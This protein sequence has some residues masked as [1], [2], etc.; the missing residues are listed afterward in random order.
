MR[1]EGHAFQVGAARIQVFNAGDLGARLEQWISTVPDEEKT[2]EERAAFQVPLQVPMQCV[3]IAL[4]G[5]SVLVDAASYDAIPGGEYAIPGYRPPDPLVA[6]LAASGVP[7]ESIDAVLIT[8]LHFDHYNG[9][10]VDRAGTLVPTYPRARHY[11]GRADLEAEETQQALNDPNTL[12]GR[13]L[14]V[15]RD[16]GLLAPVEGR[17]TVVPGISVISAP[18][19]SPGHQVVRVESEGQVLYCLGDL[20]HH[21]LEVLH[22]DWVV[23]WADRDRIA[24]SRRALVDAALQERALLIATHIRGAGR[25]VA[26]GAGIEWVHEAA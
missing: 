7:A 14:A 22:P 19:E 8:H 18:G 23:D 9:T 24:V 16:H 17:R 12:E 2:A 15:L 1:T 20:V 25:L 26:T 3:H 11:I 21:P 10:T 5:R 6:Q 13:T 4:E